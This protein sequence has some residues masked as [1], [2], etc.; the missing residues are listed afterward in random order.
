MMRILLLKN[1]SPKLVWNANWKKLTEYSTELHPTKWFAG[2][3][4][5]Y[6]LPQ[7]HKLSH[8]K[9]NL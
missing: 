7:P 8:L 5:A 2:D 6:A 9:A 4:W 3:L 1:T